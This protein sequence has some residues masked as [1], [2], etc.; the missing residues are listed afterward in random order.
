M[1][2]NVL[3]LLLATAVL[4]PGMVP[5]VCAQ[6][7]ATLSF[8][9]GGQFS[10]S[11]SNT[12]PNM[13][14]VPGDRITAISAQQ[15][16]LTDKRNTSAGGVLFSTVATKT[17]TLFVETARGQTFSVVAN[18]VAGRGQ[19][20]RLLSAEAPPRKEAHQW[21]TSHPYETLLITLGRSALTGTIPDGYGAVAPLTDGI[22]VPYGMTAAPDF[23][24]AG[25]QLR[26]D[27][28]LLGN[29]R[30]YSI[31]LR[32]QDFWKPGV[33]AVMF[34]NSART[35]LASGTLGVTVIRGTGEGRDGQHQ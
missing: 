8:A 20:Y 9:Q 12:D 24:W 23:A 11:V 35:L 3:A 4:S 17:F 32:E 27:R 2:N 33:R 15:G 18:P 13:L 30:A 14:F 1:K 16:A 6:A 26:V 7:L 29:T 10:L 34:D 19:V 21:E 22:A 31:A 5:V 28:Y 25:D